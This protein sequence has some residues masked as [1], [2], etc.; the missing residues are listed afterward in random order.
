MLIAL[1]AR[2]KVYCLFL[3]RRRKNPLKCLPGLASSPSPL[4]FFGEIVSFQRSRDKKVPL[5]KRTVKPMDVCFL[6][7]PGYLTY[8]ILNI[9]WSSEYEHIWGSLS[10][11]CSLFCPNFLIFSLGRRFLRAE[12]R[13]GGKQIDV[14]YLEDDFPPTRFLFSS[15]AEIDSRVR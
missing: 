11:I 8:F 15:F 5:W 10:Y 12:N 2:I 14:K 13:R 3:F 9:L 4:A 7:R 6:F 1:A